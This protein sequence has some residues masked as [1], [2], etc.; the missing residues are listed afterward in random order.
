MNFKKLIARATAALS[1][2]L[3]LLGGPALANEIEIEIDT[4]TTDIEPIPGPALW[5]VGDDDTTIYLFGTVHALPADVQWYDQRIERA[6]A[7]SSELVTEISMSDQAATAQAIAGAAMLTTGGTLR[8]LMTEE[9]RKEYEHALVTLG[10]PIE[11]LDPVEPWFAAMNLSLLPLL[12][13]GYDPG[14]GVEMTLEAR[15]EGKERGALE[16]VE[17]QVALFDTLPMEAQLSFLD[18]T[19]AAVPDVVTSLDAM[20]AE[21]LEGDAD[22]L[23]EMLNSE[24]NDPALYQRL[25]VDRN[26]SWAEWIEQRLAEP[27]NVFIAVGAGHLAGTGSVQDQ[28]AARG[29]E[30]T[31]ISE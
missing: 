13:S 23:A 19:V 9:D 21:W 16:T 24:M 18:Q 7:A 11:A 3:A 28:L 22:S 31:R 20:V 8:E 14:T 15:A 5:Q 30:V 2:P 1:L 12:Q 6:F 17:Q 27:G 10:L 25:L 29:I 4:G 26:A